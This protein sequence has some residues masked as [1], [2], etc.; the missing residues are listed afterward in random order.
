MLMRGG[1]GV[2]YYQVRLPRRYMNGHP[3]AARREYRR[4]AIRA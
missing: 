4:A 3:R 2:I 1:G